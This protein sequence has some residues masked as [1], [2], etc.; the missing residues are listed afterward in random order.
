M[1]LKWKGE[2][3]NAGVPTPVSPLLAP[4][5]AHGYLPKI[6]LCKLLWVVLK[7]TQ[8]HVLCDCFNCYFSWF[9][10]LV[11]KWAA[12]VFLHVFVYLNMFTHVNMTSF[13]HLKWFGVNLVLRLL[14][15][16]LYFFPTFA[17]RLHYRGRP[18]ASEVCSTNK[19]KKTGMD[20][21]LLI[22]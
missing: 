16:C 19:Q 1:W 10:I 5:K 18:P 7:T 8:G 21:H 2:C 12:E 11:P 17:R 4:L 15:R 13:I 14:S 22:G 3:E 20:A 6:F 9:N